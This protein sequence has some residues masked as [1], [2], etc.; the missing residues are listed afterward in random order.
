MALQ[1]YTRACDLSPDLVLVRERK[2]EV[3]LNLKDLHGA[4]VEL[5]VLR[6]LAPQKAYV[7]VLL[8]RMY[9]L[10]NEKGKA[11]QNFTVALSLCP[12]VSVSLALSC[13]VNSNET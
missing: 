12:Q 3:L 1:Y 8:G 10:A 11:V 13:Q 4:F 5:A 6:D 9:G 7:Y 2:A